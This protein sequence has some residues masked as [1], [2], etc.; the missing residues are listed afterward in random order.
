MIFAPVSTSA[1]SGERGSAVLIA[2]MII[3]MLSGVGVMAI[4]QST[5]I[6]V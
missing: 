5:T 3:V 4:Q 6:E 1:I 2:L